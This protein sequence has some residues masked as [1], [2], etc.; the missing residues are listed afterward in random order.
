M[1]HNKENTNEY[2]VLRRCVGGSLRV[3]FVIRVEQ[4]IRQMKLG[5]HKSKKPS[6]MYDSQGSLVCTSVDFAH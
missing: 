3:L 4:E 5:K 2:F 1:A 6:I